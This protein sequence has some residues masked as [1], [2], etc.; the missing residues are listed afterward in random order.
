MRITVQQADE[1]ANRLSG[2]SDSVEEAL[3]DALGIEA[4]DPDIIE[5]MEHVWETVDQCECC[6]WWH[7]VGDFS[8]ADEGR[9]VCYDC[10]ADGY[11]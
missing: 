2:T 11:A 6:G 9:V 10:T 7:E 3:R 5:G 4:Q 1:V 8:D